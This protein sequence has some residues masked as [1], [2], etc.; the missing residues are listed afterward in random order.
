MLA[1]F[2]HDDLTAIGLVMGARKPRKQVVTFTQRELMDPVFAVI[3]VSWY[4]N[5]KQV[6]VE[7]MQLENDVDDKEFVLGHLIKGAL[8]AGADVTVM[9]PCSPERLGI[10]Q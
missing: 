7:E 10:K 2:R 3:R 8:Q 1:T 5:G 4:R 9:T 6:D